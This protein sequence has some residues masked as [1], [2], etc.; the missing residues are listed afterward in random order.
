M[1]GCAS[2]HLPE[3]EY[4][5]RVSMRLPGSRERMVDNNFERAEPQL[6]RTPSLN[7][8]AQTP[9]YFHDGRAAT[10]EALIDDNHDQMGLTAQL[11]RSERAALL[12]FLRTL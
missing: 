11:D 1:I 7:Y 6:F 2:C 3:H 12:A 8:V 4:T 5:D 9:P 10:L